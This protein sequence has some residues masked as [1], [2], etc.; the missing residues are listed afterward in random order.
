MSS[1][2]LSGVSLIDS[3]LRFSTSVWPWRS[4]ISPRGAC[5]LISRTRLSLAAARYLSPESTC[6]YQSLKKIS[7]NITSATPPITATRNASC[8]VSVGRRSLS[9]YMSLDLQTPKAERTGLAR[10]PA[11]AAHLERVDLQNGAQQLA[12]G[13]EHRHC[14]QRVEQRGHDGV[15]DDQRAYAGA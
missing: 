12:R 9:R 4:T 13:G 11:P 5:T 2:S 10:R 1:G 6:R 3:E 14:E 7:A 15:A 8:G